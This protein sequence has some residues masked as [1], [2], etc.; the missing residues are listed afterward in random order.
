[1]S[2]TNE[3]F[4][5]FLPEACE[6]A[7]YQTLVK[8]IRAAFVIKAIW[9]K[10]SDANILSH[11]EN[12]TDPEIEIDKRHI[13]MILQ[14]HDKA[15]DSLELIAQVVGINKDPQKCML[16]SLRRDFNKK[17]IEYANTTEEV[18]Q[19]MSWWKPVFVKKETQKGEKENV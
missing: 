13:C 3:A 14:A 4:I 15:K 17:L 6:E 16:G 8:R 9:P 7:L 18:V 5:V 1:M 10:V 19:Q 11:Y 2:G 12:K